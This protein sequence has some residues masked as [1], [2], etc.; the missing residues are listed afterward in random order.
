LAER[1]GVP[2]APPSA[3]AVPDGD[4]YVVAREL[5]VDAGVHFPDAGF[6]RTIDE[7]AETAQR[8]GFPVVLKALDLA[9]KSD[10]GGVMLNLLDE[11]SVRAA[12]NDVVGRLGERLVVVESMATSGGVELIVGARHDLG[13]GPI[14]LVGLGGVQAEVSGDVVVELA[15]VDRDGA[16]VMLR[17]L[18]AF[19][20]LTGFRGSTPVDLDAVAD[21]VAAVSLALAEH[22]E[23]QALELNPVL[24]SAAGVVALD[25]HLERVAD[26]GGG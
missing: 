2:L 3:R 7:A 19:P 17:R 16:L 24:A 11:S 22:P 6:V 10:V 26:E 9:H 15:P 8:I 18:R 1:T 12:Y 21:V 13:A 14:V 4:A 25:A 20:L 5:C 23:V